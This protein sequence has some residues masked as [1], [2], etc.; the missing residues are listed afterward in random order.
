MLQDGLDWLYKA[1]I[2]SSVI[3]TRGLSTLA[4]KSRSYSIESISGDDS[5]SL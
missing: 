1:A 3:L 2:Y 4:A 5:F